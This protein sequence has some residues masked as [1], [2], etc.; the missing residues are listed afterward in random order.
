[1]AVRKG[2][3]RN[4][5]NDC[6]SAGASKPPDSLAVKLTAAGAS[7]EVVSLDGEVR[8]QVGTNTVEFVP[9]N[10]PDGG[11]S[12]VDWDILVLR[13]LLPEEVASVL[14]DGGVTL[15]HVPNQGFFFGINGQEQ[16]KLA[17]PGGAA[18]KYHPF[19][20]GDNREGARELVMSVRDR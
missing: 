5:P 17:R 20:Y 8:V 1:M 4:K 14:R 19:R 11:G 16:Y 6:M 7:C 2:K 18:E 10:L 13:R 15:S 9:A 3:K 12:S